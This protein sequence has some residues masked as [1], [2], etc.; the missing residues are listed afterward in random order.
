MKKQ[1]P[2]RKAS[3]DDALESDLVQPLVER[4]HALQGYKA[5]AQRAARRPTNPTISVIVP[6][7]NES[8]N[9]P[10]AFAG[11]PATIHEIIVVDGRSK[12]DTSEVAKHLRPEVRIVHETRK[13]KGAALTAGFAAATGDIIVM[14]DAD[15]S[16]DPQEIRRF[17]TALLEGA[18]FAKGSRFIAGGGSSDITKIR[19]AGNKFL[20]GFVNTLFGTAYTDLCYG[21]NAFWRT[22]VP[23]LNIECTGFEVETLLN[24]RA[25]RA[26]LRVVEVPSYEHDRVHGESNLHAIRDGL[27]VMR[28]IL[29]EKYD[30]RRRHPKHKVRTMEELEASDRRG[31]EVVD[32]N[33]RLCIVGPGTRMLSGMT[34]YTY[35][36]VNEMAL[37]HDVS[38]IFMRQLL[39]T[40][41]YPGADRVGK[42]ISALRLRE[43]IPSY[44]GIDWN[45]GKS[46]VKAVKFLRKERPDVLVLQWWTGTVLHSYIALA[47]AARRLGIRVVI[48]V[49]E[50]QDT[51]EA[52]MPLAAKYVK[53]FAPMLFKMTSEFFVHT[54]YDKQLMQ[55]TYGIAANR[56]RIVP[57]VNYG[58]GVET[59]AEEI[60]AVEE[61]D[62]NA[63][64]ELL[65]FGVLRPYKG[66]EDLIRA[67]DAIPADQ[68]DRYRLTIVGEVWEGQTTTLDLA[69][70][71]RYADRITINDKYVSDDEMN[72]YFRKCDMV[73][74][75][76]H[77]SSNSGPLN[78]AMAEGKPV[79]VT[80]VGGLVEVAKRYQGA[81]FCEP[82]N[83]ADLLCAI[84]QASAL[85]GSS[86]SSPVSWAE[87]ADRYALSFRRANLV[88]VDAN[89]TDERIQEL[90]DED[91]AASD[92]KSA[93]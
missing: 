56:C 16:A 15:G 2:N 50:S 64:I 27:R 9:L 12:D 69:R 47:A 73:V 8:R 37:R 3:T 13:G 71:S 48:E 62:P 84:D 19:R 52:A 87:A 38:A 43:D 93:G 39:P 5:A 75:P 77:R 79:V 55:E 30:S 23:V 83:P 70:T 36:L 61:R 51:G 80:R 88:S 86:F 11:L 82:R 85:V 41:L 72:E 46:L 32:R 10:Y 92:A 6:T 29:L 42:D 35:G 89:A 45:W 18:D 65:Y 78:T 31:A 76:Y 20:N 22:C 26:H 60:V 21:Y 40:R 67:F 4:S 7:L 33:T 14:L 25:A 1:T 63:P 91:A 49:H 28:T 68:I 59:K 57:V 90:L 17:V 53:L 34:Y 66:V 54:E 44:D 81:V 58:V 74:L 24:I